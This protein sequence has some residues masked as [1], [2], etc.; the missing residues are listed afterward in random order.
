MAATRTE[1]EVCRPKR[2]VYAMQ[3]RRANG[4]KAGF[5]SGGTAEVFNEWY[6]QL[7]LGRQI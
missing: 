7:Q 2:S 5:A 4:W 3:A 6:D 1:F